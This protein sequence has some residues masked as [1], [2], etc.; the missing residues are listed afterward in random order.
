[1]TNIRNWRE[2]KVEGGHTG[3]LIENGVKYI[4]PFT[5]A[6]APELPDGEYMIVERTVDIGDGIEYHPTDEELEGC[7][8]MVENGRTTYY[9]V[10]IK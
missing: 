10:P 1:M 9:A 6:D 5:S 7:Q 3:C 4:H 8:G 2:F